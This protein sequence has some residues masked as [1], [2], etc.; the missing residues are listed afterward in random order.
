MTRV[1]DPD[2]ATALALKALDPQLLAL[3]NCS[4]PQ[5]TGGPAKRRW[6]AHFDVAPARIC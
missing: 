2:V 1:D 5:H 3:S 6:K 4:G